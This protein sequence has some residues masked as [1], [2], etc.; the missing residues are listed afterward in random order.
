MDCSAVDSALVSN[1]AS[2]MHAIASAFLSDEAHTNKV[3]PLFLA[4]F[5]WMAIFDP[6][7]LGVPFVRDFL[8]P[9]LFRSLSF[10]TWLSKSAFRFSSFSDGVRVDVS[11]MVASTVAK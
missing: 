3:G 1:P 7:A 4:R 10:V 8:L 11:W 6:T 9:L 2:R 5:V